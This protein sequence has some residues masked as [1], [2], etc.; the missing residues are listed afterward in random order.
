V[1]RPTTWKPA[2][3]TRRSEATAWRRFA[4][5]R[6]FDV[7]DRNYLWAGKSRNQ[8]EWLGGETV[9]GTPL[10]LKELAG[11]PESSV[12]QLVL[13]AQPRPIRVPE[14]RWRSWLN[15]PVAVARFQG[16]LSCS[17]DDQSL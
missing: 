12:E 2:W 10:T 13:I 7:G 6:Q 5:E 15:D 4:V 11:I 16:H 17:D 9:T 3:P 8:L 14:L 1:T